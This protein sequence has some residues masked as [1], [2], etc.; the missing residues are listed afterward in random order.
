MHLH[1]IRPLIAPA[2]VSCLS[3]LAGCDGGATPPPAGQAATTG[4][5]GHDH[6]HSPGSDHSHDAAP[7]A[8]GE[9]DHS[10]GA[11]TELGEQQVGGFTVRASR[12]G[13]IAGAADA[14]I[15][16]WISGGTG[17]VTSVRFWIGGQDAKGSVKAK[18]ALEKDNWHTHVE[19]PSP[20]PE[21]SR[22]WIEFEAEGS[23][24]QLAG[25][26]LKA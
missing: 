8:G 9:A 19:L 22:L 5:D 3:L 6:D 4:H 10:H 11:T 16:A 15:D 24:K 20:L 25:F 26:D 17:R 14:P 2:L 12:D 21:G 13:A 1:P 23:P 7:A 18:A